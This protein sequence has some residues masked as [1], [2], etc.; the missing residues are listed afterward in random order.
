MSPPLPP[1][2]VHAPFPIEGFR[3]LRFAEDL[4]CP[5]C[6]ST[7]ICRWGRF[8]WRRRYRCSGCRRTFSDFT[9]T[10]LA[11]LKRVDLWEPHARLALQSTT[12]RAAALRLGVHPTTTFR[13]R[14]R[15]LAGLHGTDR[16]RLTGRISVDLTY[17]AHSEK[18][19]RSLTRPARRRGF[20]GFSWQ[21]PVAWVLAATD[22][23]G[24]S[25]GSCVGPRQPRIDE[26]VEALASHVAGGSTLLAQP[27]RRG[28]LARTAGRLGL[29]FE[30]ELALPLHVGHRARPEHARV[31]LFRWKAWMRRFRGVA[32]KYLDRYLVWFR[33]LERVRLGPLPRGLDA[34]YLLGAFP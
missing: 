14:H 10:P 6:R 27:N 23:L 3:R 1:Y 32:T 16:G 5:R 17:V 31:Y 12:I 22:D 26:L 30:D 20:R 29:A 24:R 15:L 34:F 19:S 9:G 18:G 11:Y 2:P 21:G 8:G 4:A 33:L 28:V 13:W 25:T 7:R